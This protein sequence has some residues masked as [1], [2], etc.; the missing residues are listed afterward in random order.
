MRVAVGSENPVKRG[1][2]EDAFEVLAAASVESVAVDSGVAEQPTGHAETVRG[3]ETRARRARDAGADVHGG[4]IEGGGAE[5]GPVMDDEFDL[6]NVARN[7]GAAGVLT[8]NGIDRRRA[9]ADAVA[10]ALGPFVTDAY[11]D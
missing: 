10:G 6:E 11:G 5:V 4:G 2:T 3:A 9:L 1:A 7:Q 8:G